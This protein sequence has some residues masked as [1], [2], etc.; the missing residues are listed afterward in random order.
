MVCQPRTQFTEWLW[1][2][3]SIYLQKLSIEVECMSCC[4]VK[5]SG[6]SRIWG[7]GAQWYAHKLFGHIPKIDMPHFL[8]AA[9]TCFQAVKIFNS[10]FRQRFEL[11]SWIWYERT[12]WRYYKTLKFT[13]QLCWTGSSQLKGGGGEM[14]PCYLPWIHNWSSNIIFA[15]S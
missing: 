8:I 9:I 5:F 2:I 10:P 1:K 11:L 3:V 12:S 6:G 4:T 7:R 13:D 14:L 15:E